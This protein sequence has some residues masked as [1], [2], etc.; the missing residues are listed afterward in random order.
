LPSATA[1]AYRQLMKTATVR[2]VQEHLPELLRVIA[3]GEEIEVT[4]KKKPV[5]RIVPWKSIRRKRQT[6]KARKALWGDH[7]DKLRAIW[8]DTP[9]PGKP[10]GEIIIEGRR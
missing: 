8:G 3:A 10:A 6:R 2:E 4:S 1:G 5:A 7:M 9:A